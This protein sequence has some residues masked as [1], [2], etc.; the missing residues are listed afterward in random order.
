MAPLDVAR[1][2]RDT[3]G[4]RHVVHLNNA[5]AALMP[6]PVLTAV[7]RHLRLEALIGGYEAADR[8]ASQTDT[9]YDELARLLNCD[10]TE[11]AV[12]ESATR[13]WQLAFHALRFASGDRI[14][15][16]EAEYESNFLAYLQ[17]ARRSGARVEVVPSDASGETDVAALEDLLDEHVKLIALT[18]VPTNGGLVNPASAIGRV[19]RRAGIPFLLDACQSA[20]QMPLAVDTLGCDLLTATGRKFLRGPRGTGFLYVRRALLERLEPPLLDLHGA[21]WT[22]PG[23]FVLRA[24]ARRFEQWETNYATKLG[25][26]AA[27]RYATQLG[28]ESIRARVFGLGR[29]LRGRLAEITGVRVHDLG[30]DP[31]AIVTF[32]VDGMTAES[33]Q[34]RL[35]AQAFNVSV[36]PPS[37]TLLDFERRRLPAL[38]RASVHYYNTRREL[39]RF[40]AAVWALHRETP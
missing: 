11:V 26:A 10:R 18:Y 39:D 30:R 4:C 5:G 22:A 35:R 40:T 14:L 6:E 27:T 8:A 17:V 28:L 38:V 3:P 34:R 24:D 31:C 36:S 9:V 25:L 13:A 32:T 1:L 7:C 12:V 19:A 33:V 37:S 21:I 29:E 23:R 15:T 20:G 16:G 2:R